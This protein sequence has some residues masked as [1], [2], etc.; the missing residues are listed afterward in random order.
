LRALYFLLADM[1]SRF[2]YL[3]QG[4]AVILAFVGIKMIMAEWY[5][6]PTWISLS[7]IAVVLT[8]AIVVSL[9]VSARRAASGTA[10]TGGA[11]APHAADEV[12]PS[13]P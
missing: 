1:H 5:H 3:Q 6:I 4:L 11:R 12:H 8:V 10:P 2:I 9:K 13:E 7:F